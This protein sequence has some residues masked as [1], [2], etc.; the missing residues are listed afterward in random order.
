MI[1]SPRIAELSGFAETSMLFTRTS[2]PRETRSVAAL[3]QKWLTWSRPFLEFTKKHG[4]LLRKSNLSQLRA[5]PRCQPYAATYDVDGRKYEDLING[6]IPFAR[7]LIELDPGESVYFFR[8]MITEEVSSVV[9]KNIFALL[10]RS[11]ATVSG[12]ERAALFSPVATAKRDDGFP[13]HSDLFM[14]PRLWLVFDDV[15]L[16]QS[17]KSTFL[18]QREFHK[19]LLQLEAMPERVR[20][21]LATLLESEIK[22]DSF[23]KFYDLTHAE[24]HPWHDELTRK[25]DERALKIKLMPGQGYLV[26]DRCWLHGRTA[27]SGR[28]SSKRFRRLVF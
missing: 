14:C 17:G 15:P 19:T 25:L 2:A 9:V 20:S 13:L 16:D 18:S 12:S 3:P 5:I 6:C 24:R 8:D 21:Q 1:A 26:N 23:D 28:I 4:A 22:H 7:S 11:L 27:A 10:R